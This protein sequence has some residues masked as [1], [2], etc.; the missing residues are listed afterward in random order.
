MIAREALALSPSERLGFLDHSCADDAALRG[1]VDTLMTMMETATIVPES[2]VSGTAPAPTIR[3][4]DTD[5]WIGRYRVLDVI[6]SGAMGVVYRAEQ[7]TPLRQ[8]ALKVIRPDVVTEALRDR[9]EQE[10]RVLARLKHPS[11][12]AIYDAGSARVDDEDC[13]YFAMELVSGEALDVRARGLP[14]D[15]RIEMLREVC[16]GVE[17]AHRRGVVHRDLKPANILVDEGDRPR[18]LDFGVARALDAEGAH[19]GELVGTLPYM[20][21]EQLRADPDTDTRA[22]VYAMGVV[23]CE[24]VTGQRPH[25]LSG[26]SRTETAAYLERTPPAPLRTL[27]P[28]APRDLEAIA[29]RALERDPERRYPSAAALSEDLARYLAREPVEARARTIGY[30]ARRYT[31]RNTGLVVAGLLGVLAIGGGVAGVSWQAVEATRG[32]NRAQEEARRVSAI[33]GF[34]TNMLTSADPEIALGEELTVRELLDTSAATD[35]SELEGQPGVEAVVRLAMANTYRGLGI[36]DNAVTQAQRAI[37]ASVVAFGEDDPN[38]ADARQSLGTT[39]T[40]MGRHDEAERELI[41]A[42]DTNR[43]VYGEDSIEAISARGELARVYHESGKPEEALVLWARCVRDAQAIVGKDDRRT[44]VLMHNLGSA[45]SALGRY[46]EA[47]ELLSE[48]VERRVRVFGPNHPQTIGAR[49]MLASTIQKLGRDAEVVEQF[50]AILAARRALYGDEHHSTYTAMGNLAV[51]LIQ[52]GELEEAEALTRVALAGYREVLGPE[53]A[54]TLV[55]INTRAYL[56][57]DMGR[58]DEAAALYR[59]QIELRE[60]T[61]GGKDPETWSSYNNLAMLLQRTD[62]ADEALPL[63]ERLL[64]LCEESLPEGHIYTALFRNNYGACLTALGRYDEARGA[65]EQSHVV[66][67]ATFPDGHPRIATSLERLA[68]LDGR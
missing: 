2:G 31:Q 22:D 36:F 65:L 43:R 13:P 23:L 59:E 64:G 48:V 10:T 29:A 8:I 6:G 49:S 68:A 34:F 63:Y 28:S 56:L 24:L 62:R 39:L 21:P 33:N 42:L 1:R 40:E 5:R 51:P 25:D 26:V 12:A 17:H 66:L 54:K 14:L 3:G 7:Q 44:L 57:E 60:R 32:W 41:A 58:D 4:N 27:D 61:T 15:R 52:L 53:H 35:A 9:F 16:A 11:I 46:Q 30:V 50:R 67:V 45:Y 55:S 19:K 37:D 18:I 47:E 20:S 38:T